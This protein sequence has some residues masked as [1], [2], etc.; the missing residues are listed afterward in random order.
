ML[1]KLQVLNITE[2]IDKAE[3]S[4]SHLR[5]ELIDHVCC[6]IESLMKKGT[7]FDEA[8]ENIKPKVGIRELE[9]VQEN[10]LLLIDK[11]YRIMKRI[12]SI[13]G[14]LSLVCLIAGSLLRIYLIPGANI[15]LFLGFLCLCFIFLPSSITIMRKENKANS[16]ILL[17]I[18]AY[19]GSIGF[20][21]GI[22]FKVMHWPGAG[23]ILPAG[24]AFLALVF[25]PVLWYNLKNKI[26]SKLE[27][28]A[29]LTGIIGGSL[30]FM[31]ILFKIQH[32]PGAAI[33]L[34]I[35]V[36]AIIFVFL[37]VYTYVKF[38]DETNVNA[39][40]IYLVYAF[41]FFVLLTL[42]LQMRMSFDIYKPFKKEIKSRTAVINYF[43]G[44][45]IY[46]ASK[47]DSLNLDVYIKI[48]DKIDIARILID[49]IKS[50]FITN[51]TP[52]KKKNPDN[53]QNIIE[54]L[55]N[56]GNPKILETIL[57]NSEKN[58]P[59]KRLKNKF[60]DIISVINKSEVPNEKKSV[61][62][63]LLNINTPSNNKNNT[64]VENLFRDKKPLLQYLA[65]LRLEQRLVL[66][67]QEFI[68]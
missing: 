61:V 53:E 35:S 39:K 66:A 65:L 13:S 44:S 4:F 15:V 25:M 47:N 49:S 56:S 28:Y 34:F 22:L 38:K 6:E 20:S 23:I 19:I 17:Y 68:N 57:Y 40:F 24:I 2:T 64:W 3:I 48:L 63:S 30:H 43:N 18:S 62:T 54:I 67:R 55:T 60:L 46:L 16:K 7:G 14:V 10:T 45:D 5:D 32:W 50:E 51:L 1:T 41:T 9:K 21:S 37:P 33:M 36:I 58:I 8:F 42:L 26:E 11:K 52:E 29:V 59:A 31:A 27:K 12:M